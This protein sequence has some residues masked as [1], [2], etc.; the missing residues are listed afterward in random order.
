MVVRLGFQVSYNKL[1]A[2]LSSSPTQPKKPQARK[3]FC[4]EHL[5]PISLREVPCETVYRG[6][7]IGELSLRRDIISKLVVEENCVLEVLIRFL[8]KSAVV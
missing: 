4:D 6:F 3:P 5:R 1:V 2:E 8:K 7:S